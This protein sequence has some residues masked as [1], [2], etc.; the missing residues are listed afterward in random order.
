MIVK[1]TFVASSNDHV[2]PALP[3]PVHHMVQRVQ[4]RS[5]QHPRLA[6]PA[7]QHLQGNIYVDKY[8]STIYLSIDIH[9]YQDIRCPCDSSA[10]SS[11]GLRGL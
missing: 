9:L 6:P 4:P 2:P 3:P 1:S 8:I 5:G 11:R 7:P 10:P